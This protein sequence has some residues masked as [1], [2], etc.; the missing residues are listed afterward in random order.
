MICVKCYG[1]TDAIA[2][3]APL[4]RMSYKVICND[5]ICE[6]FPVPQILSVADTVHTI[7]FVYVYVCPYVTLTQRC[8]L[9][10]KLSF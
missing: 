1:Q 3:L 6:Y 7:M 8:S 4:A 2:H 10:S 9:C 5:G